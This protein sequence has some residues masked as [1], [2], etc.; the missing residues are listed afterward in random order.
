MHGIAR[1][2]STEPHFGQPMKCRAIAFQQPEKLQLLSNAEDSHPVVSDRAGDQHHV[3][4]FGTRRIQL[5]FLPH[6]PH[7]RRVYKHSIRLPFADHLRIARDDP[8]PC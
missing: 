6:F 2:G 1:A 7:S 3:S 5:H 4:W 8:H